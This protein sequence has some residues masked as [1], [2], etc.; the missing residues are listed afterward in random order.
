MRRLSLTF[1]LVIL[2]SIGSSA[3]LM[4]RQGMTKQAR[5]E[6][7]KGLQAIFLNKQ[8]VAKVTFPAYKD[9]LDVKI[10]GNWDLKWVTRQIKDHGVGI[11]IGD[12]ASIT[13]LKLKDDTIEVH[14]N[15]G[16]AG[17]FMDAMMTSQAKKTLREGAGGKAPGGSR[18]NLRFGRA[19]TQDDLKDLERL[20]GYLEPV[21]E[22]TSLQQVAKRQ[23]IPDE[24][25]EAAAKKLIVVGMDKAT[26]FAIM[27]E[28]KSKNVDVN[29][30]PPTEKWIFEMANLKTRI[31]TFKEGK[32]VK[33]DEM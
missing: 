18:I 2:T 7:Q 8:L 27:G 30:D 23:S 5:E 21:V 32:V 28:P 4:A 3:P 29:A 9:G 26:V 24:F 12:K 17:T 10:D 33:I 14:L 31:V 6:A 16:G 13:D 11:E 19:I 25:K 1:L 22:T 20:I 15:G